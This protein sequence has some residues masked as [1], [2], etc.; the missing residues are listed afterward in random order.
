[1]APTARESME[2][3]V[4]FVGA[5]PATLASALHLMNQVKAHNQRVERAGGD[6]IEPPTVLVIEKG[7]AVGDHILSG[8]VMN[9]RG[10]EEL[11]PDFAQQGFPTEYVCND[12][13][14]WLYTRKHALRS[15]LTPPNFQKK[16]YHVVSLS[17]VTKWLA[18]RCEAAG[19]EIYPGFAGETLLI[20]GHK[21]VGVRIGDMGVDK[22]GKQKPNYQPGM[23]IFAKVTVLGEG[24]RGS[25]SKQLVQR[26]E[27]DGPFPQVYE[28]GIKEIW[29]VRPENHRPGRVIHGS[30]F[31][32]MLRQFNGM[33]L[34]DMKDQLVS[35]G[36]V[37]M[38]D[39]QS[40]FNDPHL[41]AQEFKTVPWMRKLLEGAEL[42]RY[43]AKA[44]PMGG[45]Y[46]QPKLYCDGAMLIGDSAGF[47]N[48][49]K[50]SGIHLA[51]KS[52]MM[53]A[54]TVVDGLKAKDFSS[55]TL[56][57]YAERY[58]RSWAYTEHREARNFHGSIEVSPLFAL[59]LNLPLMLL[60]GGRGIKDPLP[61]SAGHRHMKKLSEL[62]ERK[63][64]RKPFEFDGKLS[65]SKEHLVQFSGAQHEIDEPSHLVV[66]D[67]D[68][69]RDV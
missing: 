46:A 2:V 20:D 50:L 54:D 34:Y 26:F 19:V 65:F 67:T 69:C 44:I 55:V 23:D 53:A 22:H 29:R 51:I 35:F 68:L 63:R 25:L 31:P 6:P 66:A 15:P 18:E 17:N 45:L 42:V 16:G 14:F 40:P 24:V 39:S 52:G 30:L 64:E 60:S 33:W 21:V 41:A 27:L 4:L 9:P 59:G 49:F 32:D 38:L 37:T 5:G 3:D 10:I 57:M 28:T 11:V 8:A 56:G 43:G 58:R 12:A 7:A 1:M 47:C 62:S 61:F 48:A 36:F 13:S